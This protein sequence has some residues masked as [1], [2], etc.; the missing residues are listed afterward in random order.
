MPVFESSL[1]PTAVQSVSQTPR[2]PSAVRRMAHNDKSVLKNMPS[3]LVGKKNVKAEI[4][5]MKS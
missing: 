1:E 2:A 4:S 5:G 3:R